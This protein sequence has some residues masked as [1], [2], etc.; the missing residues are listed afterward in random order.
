MEPKEADPNT[1]IISEVFRDGFTYDNANGYKFAGPPQRTTFK[2]SDRLS[3]ICGTYRTF[4]AEYDG[5]ADQLNDR[6]TTQATALALAR[7][8]DVNRTLLCRHVENVFRNMDP[9]YV[10]EPSCADQQSL[11]HTCQLY[12]NRGGSKDLLTRARSYLAIWKAKEEMA[13]AEEAMTEATEVL[14][15]AGISLK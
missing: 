8:T 5:L 15:T 10:P 12:Q 1:F 4:G 9:S 14:Q 7:G 13:A 3:R 2:Y 6:I 11:H